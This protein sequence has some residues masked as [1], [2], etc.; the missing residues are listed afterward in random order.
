MNES[1]FLEIIAAYGSRPARWPEDERDAALALLGA[2]PSLARVMTEAAPLD[3]LLESYSVRPPENVLPGILSA[4]RQD[5]PLWLDRLLD[6]FMP[7]QYGGLAASLVLASGVLIGAL[8]PSS[9]ST[10]TPSLTT[11]DEEIYL[12]N[13][14]EDFSYE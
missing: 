6:W 14:E 9:E 8:L 5:K 11:W 1:R 3:S 10:S 13:V 2:D 12:L 7:Q 4:V